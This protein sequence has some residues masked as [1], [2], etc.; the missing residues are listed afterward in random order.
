MLG[1]GEM[2]LRP[3]FEELSTFRSSHLYDWLPLFRD[4]PAVSTA[5]IFNVPHFSIEL[6]AHEQ[7]GGARLRYRL[8]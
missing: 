8:Q 5:L 6:D 3:L 1:S 2:Q 4:D 7:S